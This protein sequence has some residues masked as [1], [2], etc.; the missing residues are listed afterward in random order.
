MKITFK[1]YRYPL[2]FYNLYFHILLIIYG[3]IFSS[4]ITFQSHVFTYPI[5]YTVVAVPLYFFNV[6]FNVWYWNNYDLND[7]DIVEINHFWEFFLALLLLCY[8]HFFY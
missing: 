4:D 1:Y 6:Y 5:I 3:L 7:T 2:T 8:V